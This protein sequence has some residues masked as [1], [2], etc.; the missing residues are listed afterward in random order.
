MFESFAVWPDPQWYFDLWDSLSRRSHARVS[1]DHV[2]SNGEG[3]RF[4]LWISRTPGNCTRRDS[5]RGCG[6][7]GLPFHA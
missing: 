1:C 3:I 5:I 2:G 7:H 6:V 4:L